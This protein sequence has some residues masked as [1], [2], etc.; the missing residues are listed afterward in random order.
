M[1]EHL[2]KEFIRSLIVIVEENHQEELNQQHFGDMT[3]STCTLLAE[4]KEFLE[5]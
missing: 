3:C 1:N 4:V 2:A 5:N